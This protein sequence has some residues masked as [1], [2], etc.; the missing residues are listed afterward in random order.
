MQHP[1]SSKAARNGELIRLK[2]RDIERY[3]GRSAFEAE[4]RPRGYHAVE[5]ADQMVN[6][7]NKRRF[8]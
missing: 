7:L 1:F 4:L 8:T 6:F 3:V 5:N 2:T